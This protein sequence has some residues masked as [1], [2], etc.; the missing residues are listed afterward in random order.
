MKLF[1]IGILIGT[2][3]TYLILD[4]YAEKRMKEYIENL[5]EREMIKKGEK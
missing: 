5:L 1:I 4:D 2:L 3:I